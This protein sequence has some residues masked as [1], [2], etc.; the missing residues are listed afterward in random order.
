MVVRLFKRSAKNLKISSAFL[1]VIVLSNLTTYQLVSS[2]GFDDDLIGKRYIQTSWIEII[3]LETVG[4]PILADLD[5]DSNIEILVSSPHKQFCLNS[6]GS[7]KWETSIQSTLTGRMV[8]ADLNEDG[9]LDII[10]TGESSVICI[11]S[12]GIKLWEYHT[13]YRLEEFLPCIFDFNNDQHLE[14]LVSTAKTP[15]QPFLLNHE[16]EFIKDFYIEMDY[17]GYWSDIFGGSPSIVDIDFDEELEILMIGSDYKLHCVSLQGEQK[18]IGETLMRGNAYFSLADLD[19]DNSLE[20]CVGNILKLYCFDHNGEVEWTY[21]QKYENKSYSLMDYD[22]CIA[23]INGDGLLEI[24]SSSY[25]WETGRGK[26]FCLNSTGGEIW[27]F[28]SINKVGSPALIDID[29]DGNLEILFCEGEKNLGVLNN[30]GQLIVYQDLEN[31]IGEPPLI[32]DIDSD[33][34]L[35]AIIVRHPRRDVYCYELRESTNSTNSWWAYGGSYQ[36]HGRPDSDGDYLDDL[37]ETNIYHTNMNS[38]DTDNDLL[39]DNWEIEYGLNPLENSTF[40]DP[41]R[42]KFTNIVEY[43]SVSNPR[44]FNNW[45]LL[46]GIYFIPLWIFVGALF[47]ISVVKI[48]SIAEVIRRS[49]TNLYIYIRVRFAQD[50]SSNRDFFQDDVDILHDFE[51]D[52]KNGKQD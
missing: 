27:N 1:I 23:D 31:M 8:V 33:S 3:G 36:H 52:L 35:E 32:A 24:V 5:R 29:N 40:Q 2:K 25:D 41:D 44:I 34:K 37:I 14:I 20:I 11:D 28:S 42:D 18:W 22:P 9:K 26:V 49:A 48:K 13:D 45:K 10:V 51:E 50:L 39:P 47:I 7:V 38:N 17:S 15:S 12:F 4:S 46:Y 43:Q 16:G 30:N 6:D 19:G 21:D